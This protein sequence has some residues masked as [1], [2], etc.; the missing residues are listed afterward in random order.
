[1]TEPMGDLRLQH[2]RRCLS[3]PDVGGV[4]E[5]FAHELLAEVDRLRV[6]IATDE[7][8]I[9]DRAVELGTYLRQQAVESEDEA[10][11]KSP[12]A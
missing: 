3:V 12:H 5:A 2:I 11:E 4:S 8:F 7:Q 1:M 9:Y 10:K 6:R